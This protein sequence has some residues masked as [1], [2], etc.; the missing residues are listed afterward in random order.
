M[1]TVICEQLRLFFRLFQAVLAETEETNVAAGNPAGEVPACVMDHIIKSISFQILYTA[2]FRTHKVAVRFGIS[3]KVIST[4][5]IRQFPDL[6][7][8]R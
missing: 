1:V 8:I 4:A 7:D 2:T 3:I 6:A 5:E